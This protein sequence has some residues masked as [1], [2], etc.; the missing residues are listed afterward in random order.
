M[1]IIRGRRQEKLYRDWVKHASLSEENVPQPEP[2]V[3]LPRGW[4]L[5][6]SLNRNTLF[7][8]TLG[9][10]LFFLSVSIGLLIVI[11]LG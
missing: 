5:A 9:A 1:N 6:L 8:I 2:A 3:R 4:R 10:A 11:L 7:Y